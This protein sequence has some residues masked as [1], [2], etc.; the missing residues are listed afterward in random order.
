VSLEAVAAVKQAVKI[1]VIG[2]GGI[3]SEK[4]AHSMTTLTGCDGVMVGRG[5]LGR[6]W[7][8]GKVLGLLSGRS[9]TFATGTT[10]F[11]VIDRH[12]RYQLQWAAP[13]V[14]VR[15]MRKHL[16]WYSAGFHGAAAFRD[17]V[18]RL[19]EVTRVMEAVKDFF[20]KAVVA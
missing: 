18:L 7:F 11:D 19:D 13:S 10:I 4:D 15:G 14:A 17:V 9:L 16:V 6:P 1:P 20:G 2:N 8:P 3:I 12:V 5:A